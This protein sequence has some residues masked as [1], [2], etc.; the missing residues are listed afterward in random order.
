MFNTRTGFSTIALITALG[1]LGIIFFKVYQRQKPYNVILIAGTSSAGKSS[2]ITE[3]EK[4][5]GNGYRVIKIDDFNTG[6]ILEKKAKAWGWNDKTQ[7]LND[8][9]DAYV[10]N[11]TGSYMGVETELSS[12]PL[13]DIHKEIFD[14]TYKAFFEYANQEAQKG[15]IIIDTVFDF[16]D[17]YD[18]FSKIMGDNKIIKVLVY[19]PLDIIE[20]RVEKRNL[21]GKPEEQRTA[22]QAFIQFPAIYKLQESPNDPIVD[23][24]SSGRMLGS[25]KKAV[26][27]F[28]K[29]LEERKIE[30]DSTAAKSQVA[31][32]NIRQFYADFVQRF[33]LNELNEIMIVPIHHYDLIMNS[34][35][36]QATANAREIMNYLQ[37]N[38]NVRNY[39]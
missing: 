20:E 31:L 23:R 34:A 25:V 12:G 13:H 11:K 1:F 37:G 22:F 9:M 28:I 8:F 36:Q 27:D 19:C 7:T 5:V 32:G 3:L 39:N 38:K 29:Q 15:N 18:Q 10:L 26:D 30:N 17:N 24:L 35:T 2:I 16:A 33:K 14:A 21:S 6:K 4:L